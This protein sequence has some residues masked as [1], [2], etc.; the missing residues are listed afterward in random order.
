MLS[1]K[2]EA[3]KSLIHGIGLFAKCE[4]S[5]GTVVWKD[6]ESVIKFQYSDVKN[7]NPKLRD[8]I[9]KYVGSGDN[10]NIHL[11]T[12][13]GIHLNH[14]CQPNIGIASDGL[15]EIALRNLRKDEEVAIN[16]LDFT[17]NKELGF[18]CT[19]GRDHN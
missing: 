10:N 7:L 8:F 14:S 12:D 19:C 17:V 13:Q 5:K 16:Y 4:I 3:R 18:N 11:D 6:D 2:I 9:I 15:T 1:S